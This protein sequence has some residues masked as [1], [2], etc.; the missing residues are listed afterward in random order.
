[1]EWGGVVRAPLPCRPV[2]RPTPSCFHSLARTHHRAL[3]GLCRLLTQ[4]SDFD[5]MLELSMQGDNSK[6]RLGGWG[7]GV[8]DR[9]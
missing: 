3:P 2:L 6:V 9:C 4:R 7:R 1:M 8:H 5:E